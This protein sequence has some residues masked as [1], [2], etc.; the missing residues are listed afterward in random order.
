MI[1]KDEVLKIHSILI[2]QF[3]GSYGVRDNEM[4]DS[5]LNRPFATFDQQ[6]LYPAAVDKAVA[7]LESIVKNH[8]FID[9]NKR[10]GYVLARLI[11]L[12]SQKE[13]NASQ[14]EKYNLVI[15]ISKGEKSFEQIQE[16]FIK[17]TK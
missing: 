6:E 15:S 3:G 5:A 16:W 4:L 10:T 11:L 17:Y 13:I 1:S 9:G 12:Q 8:P 14:N 7:I 2:D